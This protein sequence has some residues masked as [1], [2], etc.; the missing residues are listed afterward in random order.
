MASPAAGPV[1]A[2]ISVY[3][4]YRFRPAAFEDDCKIT[5]TARRV[6]LSVRR[7]SLAHPLVGAPVAT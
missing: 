7:A 3:S 5:Q 1:Q 4:I 2:E 6:N